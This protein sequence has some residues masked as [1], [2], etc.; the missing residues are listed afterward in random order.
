MVINCRLIASD[1]LVES[2]VIK[3]LKKYNHKNRIKVENKDETKVKCQ[4]L[5]YV[6][7]KKGLKS[8]K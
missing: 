1:Y 8:L 6:D 5:K 3:I 7:R 4:C 2:I